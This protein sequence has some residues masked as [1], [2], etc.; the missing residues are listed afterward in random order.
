MNTP[1]NDWIMDAMRGVR[2]HTRMAEE[3]QSQNSGV[4]GWNKEA[5]P[6]HSFWDGE[7]W[8]PV[9]EVTPLQVLRALLKDP[10]PEN[11]DTARWY[12]ETWN[13]PQE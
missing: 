11:L 9:P 13:I 4:P 7:D 12:T 3:N 8:Y 2:E 1:S 6:G 10:S 5:P